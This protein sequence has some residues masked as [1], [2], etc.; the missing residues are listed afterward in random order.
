VDSEQQYVGI[1]L[2]CRRSVIVR[3]DD[4]AM[5]LIERIAVDRHV[6]SG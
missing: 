3:M 6:D 5:E 1:D 2:H 4:A